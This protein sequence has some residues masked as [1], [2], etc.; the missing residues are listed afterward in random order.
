[1]FLTKKQDRISTAVLLLHSVSHA[2]VTN[3][4]VYIEFIINGK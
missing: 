2:S 3:K 1:M 4:R